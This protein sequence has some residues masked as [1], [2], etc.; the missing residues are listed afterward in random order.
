M[1]IPAAGVAPTEAGARPRFTPRLVTDAS[2]EAA[3]EAIRWARR[4]IA[5]EARL[6][7][8]RRER[9]GYPSGRGPADAV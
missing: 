2:G 8:L 5:W 3:A 1:A 9:D 4:R 6:D 7:A